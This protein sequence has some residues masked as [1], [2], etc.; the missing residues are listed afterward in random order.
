MQECKNPIAA[1]DFEWIF[2]CNCEGTEQLRNTGKGGDVHMEYFVGFDGGSTYLKAALFDG[3][4][5]VDTRGR[6][7]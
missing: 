7:E 1:G 3:K 2:A 4:Q 6:R 5:V